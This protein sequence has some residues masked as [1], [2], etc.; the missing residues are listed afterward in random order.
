MQEWLN[1]TLTKMDNIFFI[2][3]PTAVGKSDLAAEVAEKCNAEIISADAFQIYRGL[4]LLTAKPDTA[5]LR[6]EP[7]YLVG[8]IPLDEELNAQKFQTLAETAL[9]EI[10]S[11]GRPALI[12]GGSGFY[13]KALT[14]GL[15]RV[16]GADPNLREHLSHLS[17]DELHGRLKRLDPALAG[18]IDGKNPRRLIRA[19]EVCLTTGEPY[20]QQRAG[21]NNSARTSDPV[22]FGSETNGVFL[23]RPRVELYERI[24]RRVQAMFQDGVVE[25]VRVTGKVSITAEKTIGLREIRQ[26]IAGEIGETECIASI[27][28]ATHHYAKRQLT[29]FRRQT[30]F[31]PLNLSLLSRS[32]AI[33]WILRK[34]RLS[35]AHKDD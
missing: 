7:H 17:V 10:R 16:P 21:R 6:R 18:E 34:A 26:L 12:V 2:V 32:E 1:P 9:R 13:I 15:A 29:W 23:F 22:S 3:G 5:T 25:E 27:Q 8:K 4:D 35:F 28:K 30:S 19:L 20:S 33:E 14:H 31:S 11:H 24:D